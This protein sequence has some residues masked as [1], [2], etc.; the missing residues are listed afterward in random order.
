MKRF[1]FLLASVMLV[2][3]AMPIALAAGSETLLEINDE[4]TPLAGGETTVE[5]GKATT[6]VGDS[7]IDDAITQAIEAKAA[8]A[9]AAAATDQTAVDVKNISIQEAAYAAGSEI[10]VVK[11][12]TDSANKI[13]DNDLGLNIE[14]TNGTVGFTNDVLNSINA[15]AAK[16]TSIRV[17]VQS[18]IGEAKPEETEKTN[19]IELSGKV[20]TVTIYVDEQ[21]VS[22]F[23]GAEVTLNIEVEPSEGYEEGKEYEVTHIDSSG[24]T[25]T[26]IGTCVREPITQKLYI[27]FRTKSFSTFVIGGLLP[28][29][30][31]PVSTG[32]ETAA[33]SVN[34]GLILAVAL[35]AAAV[36]VFVLA[37]R[38]ERS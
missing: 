19:V 10:S 23:G 31:S 18:Y 8:A 14:T 25:E 6:E 15:Q 32:S 29:V 12:T 36:G 20:V 34:Y 17:E 33:P 3:M 4:A 16:G 27:V 1:A 35:G 7:D 2:M 37:N 5:S 26:L 24:N 30:T 9:E 38:K 13:A 22:S 11:I 28:S 21:K